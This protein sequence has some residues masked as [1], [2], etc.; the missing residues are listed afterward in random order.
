[1]NPTYPD[2]RVQLSGGNGNAFAI[3]AAVSGALRRE[4]GKEA[5]DA[6]AREAM[7]QGSYYDLLRLA[8]S[9]V[10]VS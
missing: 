5:A 3:I 1:M 6:F 4:V 7:D 8:M 9:T 10:E 2:V